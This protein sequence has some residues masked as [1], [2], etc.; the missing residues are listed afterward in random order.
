[1]VI[2]TI[3]RPAVNGA[4][5]AGQ[6]EVVRAF[7]AAGDVQVVDWRAAVR[8]DPGMIKGD[9]VHASAAGYA[10][11]GALFAQAIGDCL[12]SAIAGIPAPRDGASAARRAPRPRAPRRHPA[13]IDWA[14]AIGRGPTGA[15]AGTIGSAARAVSAALRAMRTAVVGTGPEPLLGVPEP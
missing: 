3:S 5:V 14:M 1:M 6:N 11:R 8:S 12:T 4:T 10:L 9:G 7:A 2:A 13:R 15:V